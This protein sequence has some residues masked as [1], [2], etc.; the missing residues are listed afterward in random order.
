ML[1]VFYCPFDLLHRG[2]PVGPHLP[3]GHRLACSSCVM[4]SMHVVCSI[5]DVIPV[6]LHR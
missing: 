3:P 5:L 2:P 1:L 4:A 6:A